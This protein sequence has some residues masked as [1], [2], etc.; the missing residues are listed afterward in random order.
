MAAGNFKFGQSVTVFDLTNPTSPQRGVDVNSVFRL[1]GQAME[2]N[3]VFMCGTND[4]NPV[5]N[6]AAHCWDA[7]STNSLVWKGSLTTPY[8]SGVAGVE[9]NDIAA[10]N[11]LAYIAAGDSG[12]WVLDLRLGQASKVVSRFTGGLPPQAR[13][14]AVKGN[15]AYLVCWGQKHD[16][17]IYDGAYLQVLD[18]SNSKVPILLGSQEPFGQYNAKISGSLLATTAWLNDRWVIMIYEIDQAGWPQI[19]GYYDPADRFGWLEI[20]KVKGNYLYVKN[21]NYLDIVDV[22][23]PA[24]PVLWARQS[25]LGELYDVAVRGDY[26]YMGEAVGIRIW[27]GPSCCVGERGNLNDMG[28]VDLA[29]L[30]LMVSYLTGG[31][32]SPTCMSEADVNQSGVVDLS[33]LSGLVSYLT[34]GGYQLPACP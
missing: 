26:V 18:I 11:G 21:G 29:D 17:Y 28:V 9:F 23:N 30:S 33:D 22:S 24:S 16:G 20:L 2:G 19:A 13:S 7:T 34:G 6:S 15:R 8:L 5:G 1:M 32:S 14:I 12:M 3:L 27:K 31:G 10:M 4:G 25:A